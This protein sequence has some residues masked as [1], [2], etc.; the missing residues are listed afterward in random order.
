MFT[1][2]RSEGGSSEVPCFEADLVA[3]DNTHVLTEHSEQ[4]VLLGAVSSDTLGEGEYAYPAVLGLPG[5]LQPLS[6]GMRDTILGWDTTEIGNLLR[7]HLLSNGHPALNATQK[8]LDR[9]KKLQHLVTSHPRMSLFDLAS[10]VIPV[11]KRDFQ[12]AAERGDMGPFP[13]WFHRL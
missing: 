1:I 7:A 8:C 12:E 3:V 6:A 4:R 5:A 10:E 9:I 2:K 13:V 11:Y